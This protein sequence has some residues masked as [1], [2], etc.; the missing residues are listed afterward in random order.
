MINK[1]YIAQLS[2]MNDHQFTSN[3]GW[4]PVLQLLCVI[5]LKGRCLLVGSILGSLLKAIALI[6]LI[7]LIIIIAMFVFGVLLKLMFFFFWIIV[8]IVVIAAVLWLVL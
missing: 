1:L 7:A 2:M 8:I 5:A 4:N 6:I 3:N